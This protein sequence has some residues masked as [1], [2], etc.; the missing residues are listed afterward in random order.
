METLIRLF[1]VLGAV[2]MLA[3]L[4]FVAVAGRALV[5]R[6]RPPRTVEEQA[7]WA[8]RRYARIRDQER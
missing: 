5:R 3:V 2:A 8:E 6:G 7:A 1:A 4:L